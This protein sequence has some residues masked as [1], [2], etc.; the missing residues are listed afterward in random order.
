MGGRISGITGAATGH[1]I[2]FT[3][4]V[5][6]TG[7]RSHGGEQRNV[8]HVALAV[9]RSERRLPRRFGGA[10]CATR[11]ILLVGSRASALAS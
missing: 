5:E 8:G 3:N 2:C 1:M 7:R 11:R 9:I 6:A 4:H 10:A